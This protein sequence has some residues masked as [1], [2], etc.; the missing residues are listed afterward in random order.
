MV[1]ELGRGSELAKADIKAA[2][3]I[4]PVH[5][6]DCQLLAMKWQGDVYIDTALPFGLQSAPKLFNVI[7]D[8][9]EWCVKEAGTK[10]LWQYLDDF[11]TVGK[12]GSG[13]WNHPKPCVQLFGSPTGN[14]KM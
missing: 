11:I 6:Q 4:V 7:A 1:Q 9:L 5:P 2:Y 10:F 14:R 12:A 8:A 13:E 3:R